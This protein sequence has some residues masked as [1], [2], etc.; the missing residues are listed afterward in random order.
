MSA[1]VESTY[2]G[3]MSQVL[4]IEHIFS[5]LASLKIRLT[6]HIAHR[7]VQSEADTSLWLWSSSGMLVIQHSE[8]QLSAPC[9]SDESQGERKPKRERKI[10]E[11]PTR[12]GGFAIK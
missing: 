11:V 12:C 5:C 8:V 1:S 2:T 6:W 7:F 10:A 3:H 4:T 9:F